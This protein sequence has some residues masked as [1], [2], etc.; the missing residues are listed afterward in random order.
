MLQQTFLFL[1]IS[2]QTGVFYAIFNH[3]ITGANRCSE[4]L[5][6][7][8][9]ASITRSHRCNYCNNHRRYRWLVCR[10]S[11]KQDRDRTVRK[12]L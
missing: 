9:R 1:V 6:K 10:Q 7:R 11:R 4:Q 8:N 5:F 3:T 2:K 12:K